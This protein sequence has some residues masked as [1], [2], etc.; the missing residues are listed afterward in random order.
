MYITRADSRYGHIY[1]IQNDGRSWYN[2]AMLQV[3]QPLTHGLSLNMN[4]TFSHALDDVGNSP[5]GIGVGSSNIDFAADKGSSAS[6]QRQ[7]ATIDFIWRPKLSSASAP[8]RTLLNGW[9]IS[10]IAT[11]ASARSATALILMSGQQF[12]S[13]TPD[14]NTALNGSG[15]WARV[16]FYPVNSL[17]MSPEKNLDARLARTI[18]FGERIKL[19]MLAQAFN[20]F[21]SQWTT[22]VNTVAFVAV[23]G[24]LKPVAGAG[25]PNASA[26]YDTPTARRCEVALRLVF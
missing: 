14:Y 4:Y 24:L 18:S 6:D 1:Q 9:E 22:G 3:R 12:A 15:G 13:T 10:G 25:A 19:T 20:V 21:N 8:L 23:S 5:N 17:R 26:V 11:L 16:P 2:A 7:R